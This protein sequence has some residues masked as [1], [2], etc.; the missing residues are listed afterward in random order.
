VIIDSSAI[1]AIVREE[2]EANSILNLIEC[3]RGPLRMSA[4]NFL[5]TGIVVDGARNA[6]YSARFEDLIARLNLEIIPVSEAQ[7]RI[8]RRAYRAYGKGSGHPA[9][10]NFGDCFA[11]ALSW[12]SG[13]PLL[14][15]GDDFIHTD[16]EAAS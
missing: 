10:L 12:E 6:E 1:I 2:P 16:I 15:K 13:E 5:E 7:A 9:Q 11:Y 8:A 3:G 14:Y 4:G